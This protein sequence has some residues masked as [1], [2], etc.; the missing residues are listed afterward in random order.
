MPEGWMIDREGR[1]LTDPKRADEG[2][3]LPLGGGAATR[4]TAWRSSSA[5]SPAR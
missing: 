4:A 1:P 3:L 5:S 2:F